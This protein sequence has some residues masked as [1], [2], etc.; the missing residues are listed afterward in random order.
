MKTEP[1]SQARDL[2]K[3]QTPAE[4][5]LWYR[6]RGRQLNGRKWRRQ[7]VIEPYIVDFFCAEV[8]L[9]VEVDGDVHAFQE[10]R[11]IRRQA[12]LESQGLKV[13]RFTNNDV[14]KN[15]EGVLTRLWELTQ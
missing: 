5:T 7:Q 15:L 4:Q 2:R 9:V 8:R 6:L 11:D 12:Y 1:A 3:A 13:V 10:E 14:M